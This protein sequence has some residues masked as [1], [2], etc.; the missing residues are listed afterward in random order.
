MIELLVLSISLL[1]AIGVIV[2]LPSLIMPVLFCYGRDYGSALFWLKRYF[3]NDMAIYTPFDLV[4]L[5]IL[6]DR[7]DEISGVYRAYEQK[8]NIGSEYFVHAWVAAHAGEW[9]VAEV[10]LGELRKYTIMND[11]DLDKLAAAITR[12]SSKE[13]DMLYL[14][15]MNGKAFITPSLFRVTLVSLAG[16][17]ALAG[18]TAVV[19]YL[20]LRIANLLV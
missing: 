2:L 5:Y 15:D 4:Y 20:V 9:H 14:V 13:I 10:A 16:A 12:R 1:F 6:N 8:G 17:L 11:V 7:A 3:K 18:V 19:V